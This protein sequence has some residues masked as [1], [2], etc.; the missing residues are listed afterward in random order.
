[1]KLCLENYVYSVF[2]YEICGQ[3]CSVSLAYLPVQVGSNRRENNGGRVVS[4][5][6]HFIYKVFIVS[7]LACP[8]IGLPACLII[9]LI[10]I[11][12]LCGGHSLQTGAGIAKTVTPTQHTNRDYTFKQKYKQQLVLWPV[13]FYISTILLKV[14]HNARNKTACE[15]TPDFHSIILR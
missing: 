7:N 5:R 2:K 11:C 10:M 9:R 14:P 3:F 15:Q 13:P 1:M 12:I 4:H 8:S 6:T